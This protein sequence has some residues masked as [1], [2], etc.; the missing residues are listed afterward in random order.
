[1]ARTWIRAGRRLGAAWVAA[2]GL[3]APMARAE[4][5]RAACTATLSGRRVVVRPE[6]FAFI[7]PELDRLVRLG[8]AVER[9]LAEAQAR[10][11]R[12]RTEQDRRMLA[13]A[14]R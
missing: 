7:S 8:A 14:S 3:L 10:R 12:A 1:M 6:A 5:P 9:E 11:E 2:A 13:R 4:E